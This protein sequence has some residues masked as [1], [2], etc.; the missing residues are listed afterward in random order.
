MP[1]CKS[2]KRDMR[3]RVARTRGSLGQE[4]SRGWKREREEGRR[5]LVGGGWKRVSRVGRRVKKG[6]TS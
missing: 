2:A 6:E 5:V 3:R 4:R 1:E